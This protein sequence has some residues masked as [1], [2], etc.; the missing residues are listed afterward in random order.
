MRSANRPMQPAFVSGQPFKFV[1]WRGR[2]YKLTID[3]RI[4]YE[5][6]R[7]SLNE[8]IEYLDRILNPRRFGR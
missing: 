3:E 1:P 2:K 4:D 6:A 8:K 5:I 7:M